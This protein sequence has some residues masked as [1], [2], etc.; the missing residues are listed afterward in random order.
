ME[1]LKEREMKL[2]SRKRAVVTVDKKST[3][4]RHELVSDLAKK[5]NVKP[6]QIVIKHIYS[7]FGKASSKVIVHVYHDS[8]KIK[9]FE[10]PNL[11]KKHQKKEAKKEGE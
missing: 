4:A 7:Q 5:F 8:E 6:E 1:I 11:L 9:V 10:H 2:L 3:P